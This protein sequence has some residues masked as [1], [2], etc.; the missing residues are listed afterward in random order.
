M[1]ESLF[2]TWNT[3]NG[4]SIQQFIDVFHTFNPPD[5]L[6]QHYFV[7]NPTTG[8]GV[9]PK[10]DFTSSGNP[11]LVGNPDAI[12][13][14]KGKASIPAPHNATDINWL[15]VVNI[16]G[17]AGGK[18]ADEVL[19]TSTVGG[20]PPTSCEFGETEDISVKYTSFYC[21]CPCFSAHQPETDCF[22]LLGFFGG[23]LAQ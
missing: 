3:T 19:R 10:W 14:A 22:T 13:V 4:T 8:Q 1:P 7:Q 11:Q 18:V 23:S 9:S 6:A 17:A 2:E 15:D 5:I 16:G 12:I 21:A 20:Q